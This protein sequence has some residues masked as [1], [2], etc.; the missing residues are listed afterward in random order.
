MKFY[1]ALEQWRKLAGMDRKPRTKKY[2]AEIVGIFRRHWPDSGQPVESITTKQATDFMLSI[3]DYS[4]TRFNAVLSALKRI[5]PA[6]KSLK[7]RAVT[8][9]NREPVNQ[10][11]FSALLDELEKAH[12]GHGILVIRFLSQTGL[13][14]NEARQ[15]RWSDVK[16]G[17]LSIPAGITKNGRPR[18][19]PFINGLRDTLDRLRNVSDRSGLV[20]PQTECRTALYNACR[21]AGLP[22][23]THHDFRHLFATRCIESGVDV[24]TVARWLGHSDGGAL[25][26]RLYFHLAGT[27]SQ[28]QAAKV[29]I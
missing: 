29:K 24:P 12:R 11:Q 28:Q 6:A 26:G 20:L 21:R 2:H 17:F 25:L 10:L 16:E 15:L 27:H 19:I 3:A 5:T 22:K 7:Y 1:Q 23:L 18:A 8:I 4:A 14:I 9:R 13:R